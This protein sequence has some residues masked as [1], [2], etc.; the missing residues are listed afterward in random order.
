MLVACLGPAI[1]SVPVQAHP[2]GQLIASI[3]GNEEVFNAVV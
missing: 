2:P 1:E 3:D